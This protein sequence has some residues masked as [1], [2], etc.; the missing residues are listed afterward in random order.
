M[1]GLK[2]AP[3][4]LPRCL[5]HF[6]VDILPI[7]E[8][9][10]RKATGPWSASAMDLIR[11]ILSRFLSLFRRRHLDGELEEELHAHIAFAAEEHMRRGMPERQARAAA[12]R[13]FGG[14]AQVKERYRNQRGMPMLEQM[15]WDVR[16]GF[17]QLRKSPGFAIT[18]ILTL[19][20]G[21]GANT[22]I[23]TLIDSILL[24]PLPFAQQDRLVSLAADGFFPKGWIRALQ[25]NSQS[26]ASISAYGENAESNVAGVDTSERVF[27]SRV[28]VNFFDTLGVHP[29]LGS[30]FSAENAVEG[31]DHVVVLSHGYW[32]E[33]FGASPAVLGQM[34]RI[35]GVSRRIVGVMPAGIHFPYAD[36]RFVLPVAFKGGDATDPWLGYDLRGLGRLKDGVAPSSARA[37]LRRLQPLLLSSFPWR[38]PDSWAADTNVVPLLD[39]VVGDTRPRLMLL[40]AAVGLVLLI[41]CAN[42]AN[43]MLAKAASREREMAIRGALGASAGR[44]VSQLLA[45]S[46]LIGVLAGVA[47]LG[48]AYGTLRGLTLVLPADTPR[49]AEIGLHWHVFLFAGVASVLTGVLFGLVPALKMAS[50][51]LQQTLRS[52]S[53]SV[54]GKGA[55]F[56]VSM[57]LVVGQIALSVVVITTAGLLL[58]SLYG[59]SKVNPGFSTNRVTT[60]EVSLDATACREPGHCLGFFQE[61][62]RRAQGI[63]GVESAALVSSLPMS[64]YDL[65]YVYDA[66]GH[67]REA[68]QGALQA[69]GRSVS[70]DYFSVIGVRLL[71][72]RL[73]TDADQTGTS[74]AVVINQHMAERLWP[75]QDPIGKHLESVVDEKTPAVFDAKIASIVVG[76][77]SNTHHDA[78]QNGFGDEAYLPM[79]AKNESPAMSILLSSRLPASQVASMLRKTVASID[80]FAPVT[81][82]RTLDEVVSSSVS[83]TRALTV[84]LLGFGALAVGVGAVGVYSLIAYIVNWRTREIGIRLALG[85][86]KRGILGLVFRQSILLS[87]MGSALGLGAAIGSARLLRGFLF[88]VHPLDPLTFCAVPLL[89]LLLAL[90]AAW[91]PARRAASIDPMCALRSE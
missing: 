75:N 14:V 84:L 49:M 32:R 72:G 31:Q 86:S 79:T 22:A 26:F 55:S 16:F 58:H 2:P 62:V 46:V 91:I 68:R 52:G 59:L 71:R 45:E 47:G 74:R 70:T 27:G 78:L 29:A 1:Y 36:T 20:L 48:I 88:E 80:P 51:H 35:D 11:V 81:R 90:L 40:F 73:L 4:K 5:F 33:R 85:A 44:I 60:A 9:I 61:L 42:V 82:V 38:M 8:F 41:A 24:Q 87:A 66:E 50:P 64:G 53:L 17:R 76:V 39:E 30:F 65:S 69:A 12:M 34:I 57:A 25:Q 15:S 67:P 6:P 56:R 3:F 7:R 21:V 63:T 13:S 37:E 77:V 89:M 19:A 23:F 28:M 83:A 18:A 10:C 54:I 43:L